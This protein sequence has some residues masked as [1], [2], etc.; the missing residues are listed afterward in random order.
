MVYERKRR[1]PRLNDVGSSEILTC[2]GDA[3]V[4]MLD[5]RLLLVAHR[6]YSDITW[7]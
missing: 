7:V 5:V 3:D 4:S 6:F 1:D 2:R